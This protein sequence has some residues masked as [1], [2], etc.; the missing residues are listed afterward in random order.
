MYA[1]MLALREAA[2]EHRNAYGSWPT[3]AGLSG[4]AAPV[5]CW[6]SGYRLTSSGHVRSVGA[7]GID[8]G[9]LGD[10]WGTDFGPREA[11]VMPGESRALPWVVGGA[12]ALG[13]GA[14]FLTIATRRGRVIG[15]A[16]S[17]RGV[18]GSI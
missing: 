16:L 10:D 15:A 11:V 5:D 1:E 9:G 2:V 12:C 8:E 3:L 4:G 18:G 17:E 13:L 6:G 7:N 14:V